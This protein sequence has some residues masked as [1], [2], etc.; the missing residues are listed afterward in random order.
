MANNNDEN[1]SLMRPFLPLYLEE[2]AKKKNCIPKK[3]QY[4]YQE[5]I[6]HGWYLDTGGKNAIFCVCHE[7]RKEGIPKYIFKK[8]A[9]IHPALFFPEFGLFKEFNLKENQKNQLLKTGIYICEGWKGALSLAYLGQTALAMYGCQNGAYA[10]EHLKFLN[11]D[12][13][14]P[15][16][17]VGDAD[18][19]WNPNVLKGYQ[20]CIKELSS[21]VTKPLFFKTFLPRNSIKN[22]EFFMS[23]DS[24]DDVIRENMPIEEFQSLLFTIDVELA[25]KKNLESVTKWTQTFNVQ[26][27]P[28]KNIHKI[29]DWVLNTYEGRVKYNSETQDVFMYSPKTY[30]W[31]VTTLNVMVNDAISLA[32]DQHK[33]LHANMLPAIKT[34]ISMWTLKREE[35]TPFYESYGRMGF[36]NGA[37][38]YNQKRLLPHGPDNSLWGLLPYNQIDMGA[39]MTI[40]D[41]C[42]TICKW[43][44]W[45]VGDYN[46]NPNPSLRIKIEFQINILLAFMY[47]S[48]LQIGNLQRFLFLEG[49]SAS[50][51]STYFKL[52]QSLLPKQKNYSTTTTQ[53][54]GTFGLQFLTDNPIYLIVLP[55]MGDGVANLFVDRLRVLISSQEPI[56]IQRKFMPASTVIFDGLLVCASNKNPFA[57][58][59]S[60]GLVD[61]RMTYLRFSNRISSEHQKDWDELFPPTELEQFI[62]FALQQ[63]PRI[64]RKFIHN[65]NKSPNQRALINE[66]Y[67]DEMAFNTISTFIRTCLK[68]VPENYVFLGQDGS[69]YTHYMAFIDLKNKNIT[70]IDN[71]LKGVSYT[72]FRQQ[73]LSIMQTLFPNW[74]VHIQR[75]RLD[76]KKYRVV[77][78]IQLIPTVENPHLIEQN[79]D[80]DHIETSYNNMPWWYRLP[81]DVLK[82]SLTQK[83]E[84]S[85]NIE[86]N[87][88]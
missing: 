85:T 66:L 65:I 5:K 26:V 22:G 32:W 82:K 49:P 53:V 41:I 12:P 45:C 24:P 60:E 7:E 80:E 54:C 39:Q 56:S 57:K 83:N 69:L 74:V 11:I 87:L 20:S 9:P 36:Q 61:R 62:S 51:K 18:V 68:Y 31:S 40:N 30:C 63:K 77:T 35:M 78:N 86:T 75:K 8:N 29:V 3:G 23:K 33:W 58:N 52:L 27:T 67:C 47:A 48:V 19:L 6:L 38:D 46:P 16:V 14:T 1:S 2:W 79:I 59:Q 72:L 71:R 28:Q 84:L 25:L 17:I 37:W 76:G 21:L 34:A 42:P 70:K 73:I 13:Q 64:I 10:T 4:I 81:V 55:D 15:I 43:L 44:Y 88:Q 50:G